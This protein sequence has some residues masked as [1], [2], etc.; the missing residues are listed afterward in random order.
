VARRA[1]ATVVRQSGRSRLSLEPLENRDLFSANP[2]VQAISLTTT[3]ITSASTV[4]FTVTFSEPVTGVDSTDFQPT[5][6][7]T[8]AEALTQVTPDSSSVFTVTVSGITGNGTLGLNIVNNSGI[9]DLAGNA[10]MQG[11][12]VPVSFLAP[13]IYNTYPAGVTEL[14]E[15][16]INGDGKP[17]I[18][19]CQYSYQ[20]QNNNSVSVLLNNGDGTFQPAQTIQIPLHQGFYYFR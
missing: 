6:T 8:V 15:A 12:N 5:V 19:T 17:D 20:A 14:A 16:D 1:E 11:N 13:Q 2:Y 10:F 18:I 3:P 4:S 7:G 9:Q